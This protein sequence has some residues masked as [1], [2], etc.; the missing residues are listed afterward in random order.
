MTWFAAMNINPQRRGGRKLI[1]SPQVMH[2]AVMAAF[3][4]GALDRVEGRPLWR[5]D[6]DKPVY[7]LYIVS[8]LRPDLQHII[9]QAG[10]QGQR[11]DATPYT[12]FL[13]RLRKGQ[14]WGFRFA[15]NPTKR[16][17]AHSGRGELQ[18][19]RSVTQQMQWLLERSSRWGFTIPNIEIPTIGNSPAEGVET[20]SSR[21]YPDVRVTSRD[22]R[23]FS[24]RDA[25]GKKASTVTIVQAQYE[26]TL[27]ISDVDALRYSLTNG[28]GRGKA[29]GCGLLTL[30]E[31]R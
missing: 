31:Q 22:V 25:E 24:R 1:G 8:P 12:P 6:I 13:D 17:P 18:P 14:R 20:D 10:W 19:Q 27:E 2:A 7:R 29:Y 11:W 21:I 4:P 28:I 30:K 9:E 5:L 3:E 23:R 16:G 15:A 26:G